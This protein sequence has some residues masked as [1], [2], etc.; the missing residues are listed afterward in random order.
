M[1]NS[2]LALFVGLVFFLSANQASAGIIHHDFNQLLPGGFMAEYFDLDQDGIPADDLGLG[3][4]GFL[5]SGMM[6]VDNTN[7]MMVTDGVLSIGSIVNSTANMRTDDFLVTLSQGENYL[8]TR[9]VSGCSM[10]YGFLTITLDGD[11]MF[12]SSF[13]Y[14]E[15][16]N[17]SITIASTV[18]VPEPGSIALLGAGLFGIAW[19]RRKRI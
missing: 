11:Q 18:S 1:R 3:D 8:G 14:E 4:A 17:Q 19:M 15:V 7:T 16:A 10:C 9:G 6:L 13:T 2:V 12:L 5:Q